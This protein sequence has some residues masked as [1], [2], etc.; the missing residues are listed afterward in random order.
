MPSHLQ[1]WLC[2]P[3]IRESNQ[4]WFTGSTAR[5][6][7][8]GVCESENQEPS[9]LLTSLPSALARQ[10][11]LQW[12]SQCCVHSPGSSLSRAGWPRLDHV[13]RVRG[14]PADG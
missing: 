10:P 6:R 3:R 1:A 7:V 13:C 8:P 9:R 2:E 11:P 12:G 4:T 5:P 14:Q